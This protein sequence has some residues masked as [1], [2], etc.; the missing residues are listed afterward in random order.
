MIGRPA[1]GADP[2]DDVNLIAHRG[3]AGQY[4]ENTV[5]A[6]RSAAP[7]V[8]M[9]EIDVR[10]CGSGEL[11]VFHDEDLGRLTDETG[12]V[13]ETDWETLRTV[14]IGGSSEPISRLESL[15]GAVPADVAVNVELKHDGM[16][17]DLLDVSKRYEN[18][19]LFSS[20]WADALREIR[21]LDPGANLAYVFFDGPELALSVASEI[22]CTAVHP[23]IDLLSATDFIDEAHALGVDVNAWTVTDRAIGTDLIAAGVDGLFVDRWDVFRTDGYS[24]Y[25]ESR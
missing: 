9:I 12:V 7:H 10:R 17:A 3:C 21:R 13:A 22:G 5:F 14:T 18:E 16:A 4:P 8:E 6:V 24:D 23:S 20:L 2:T 19:L 1:T 11:V 15:L 25:R